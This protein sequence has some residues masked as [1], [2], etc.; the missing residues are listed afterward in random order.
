VDWIIGFFV[1]D[2]L[3]AVLIGIFIAKRIKEWST[4]RQQEINKLLNAATPLN[5]T[6]NRADADKLPP[7]VRRFMLKAVKE[8]A[9]CISTARLK[10]NG[11]MRFNDRWIKLDARQYYSVQ[12]AGF[13]WDAK[14]KLGP[15]WITARDRYQNHKGNMLI[16]ILSALPLFD[17]KSREMD[18]AS[19]LRHLS[20]LPWLPT[21]LLADNI[22]WDNIDDRS[23]KATITD[24][25]L[26]ASGTFYFNEQDEITGFAAPERFRSD[27][28]KMEPWSGNFSN[29]QEF[30]GYRIP[31]AARAVWNAPDG[32]FEYIQLA[33]SEAAF[34]LPPG[35]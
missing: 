24:G 8:G 12:P 22:H 25:D 27:S 2:F 10:Q 17:V 30:G 19:I 1:V 9:A 34:N 16:K 28:G 20:E 7:P 31:T 29:Y 33:I 13:I 11:R 3:L 21:A 35:D 14:M 5:K 6:F 26:S 23:A 18:H 32:D 15:A 4:A